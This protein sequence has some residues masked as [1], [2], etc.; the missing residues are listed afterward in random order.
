MGKLAAS[1]IHSIYGL[2]SAIPV[3]AIPLLMGGVSFILFWMVVLALTNGLFFSLSMGIFV[4]SL[5]RNDRTA[6]GVSFALVL[7]FSIGLLVLPGLINELCELRLSIETLMFF[8]LGSPVCPIACAFGTWLP[9]STSSDFWISLVSTHCFGWILIG[10]ACGITPRSWQEKSGG[11]NVQSWSERLA[12]W[13]Y[14]SQE[15]RF[16]ARRRL[17]ETNAFLWL[18]ARNRLRHILLWVMLGWEAAVIG[19]IIVKNGNDAVTIPASIFIAFTLNTTLKLWVASESCRQIID[20]RRQSS[21]ELLLSTP[22]SVKEILHGQRLAMKSL[23]QIPIF[24]VLVAD[25]ILMVCSTAAADASDATMCAGVFIC[26]MAAFVADCRAL[27]WVGMWLGLSC[28][29][30]KRASGG[31]AFRILALPTMIWFVI[32]AGMH[33]NSPE[34]ALLLWLVFGLAADGLFGA[35]AY[36]RLE[37]EFR[38]CAMERYQPPKPGFLQQLFKQGE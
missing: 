14:G 21:L 3:L 10:L 16:A 19:Y 37:N 17:L 38:Q 20:E 15:W 24:C 1:S 26:G 33:G 4:S 9:K 8:A 18:S 25:S 7:L 35:W 22:M 5:C 29:N 27:A 28:K 6:Y 31:A 12:R 32:I 23:F 30:A 36:S 2:L 11:K 34:A 13:T